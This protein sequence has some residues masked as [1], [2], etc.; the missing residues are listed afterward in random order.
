VTLLAQVDFPNTAWLTNSRTWE[1]IASNLVEHVQL[2][3][4]GVLVGLLV[5]APLALLAVR[6]PSLKTAL[7]TLGGVLYTIPSLAMFLFIIVVLGTGF[8]TT[9]L[10]IGLGLYALLILLRNIVT[11]L[12][13]VPPDIREAGEAMGY[14]RNQLLLRVEL[15]VALPV[16][17]AGVRIATIS[18]IG[19]VTITVF[20]GGGGLGRLFLTGYTRRD[21]TIVLVGVVLTF[22]LALV[23]DALLMLA[24][25]RL[26]PWSRESAS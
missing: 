13:A 9:S 7:L 15:P 6:R 11:G 1:R 25:R 2:T 3:A 21:L 17:L 14:T 18:T 8:G 26:S 12:E 10:V 5:A 24:Q 20:F 16:I 19:L 4:F 23:A 22:L